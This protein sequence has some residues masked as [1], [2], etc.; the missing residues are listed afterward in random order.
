MITPTDHAE[1]RLRDETLQHMRDMMREAVRDGLKESIND[2]AIE[3]FWAG[4]LALLQRQATQHAGR[5]VLG[6]LMGIVR[7]AGV[8]LV[9]GGVVYAVGGWSA[10][11]ALFKTIFNGGAT[12]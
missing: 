11:A 2:E 10:L 1:V 5:F 6:G 12:P 7:K 4:G 8:F 3:R 9:L